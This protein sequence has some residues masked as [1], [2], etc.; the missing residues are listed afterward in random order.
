[1]KKIVALILSL[2]CFSASA[3][4]L[5]S[6]VL[7]NS[8]VFSCDNN[9]RYYQ[10]TNTLGYPIYIKRITVEMGVTF[11]GT[12][13]YLAIVTRQSDNAIMLRNGWD[14]YANPTAPITTHVSFAPDWFLLV[15][16]DSIWLA[17]Q[18]AGFG[19]SIPSAAA[20]ITVG[21]TLSP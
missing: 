3:V 8:G 17:A 6:A 7:M 21:Y 14:R 9:P 1:M 11:N 20:V 19:T 2:V 12:A 16:G 4:D 15:N 13:D 18:C 5:R 10:W